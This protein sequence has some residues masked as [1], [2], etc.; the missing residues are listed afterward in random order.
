MLKAE[1]NN[2]PSNPRKYVVAKVVNNQLWYWMSFDT[3]KGA[4]ESADNA[5][6]NAIV[7]EVEEQNNGIQ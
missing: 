1:V 5:G 4:E 6:D 2:M 7:L 3:E